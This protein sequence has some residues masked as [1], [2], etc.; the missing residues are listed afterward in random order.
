MAAFA[1]I[2]LV[3]VLM[4]WL[5]SRREAKWRSALEVLSEQLGF[6]RESEAKDAFVGEHQ[7]WR[8]WMGLQPHDVGKESKVLLPTL[9]LDVLAELPRDFVAVP[10]SWTRFLRR[11][12]LR[13]I[14][15]ARDRELDK[16]FIF[17]CDFV[18]QAK[19]LVMD[20]G[21]R[22]ALV[23]LGDGPVVGFIEKNQVG[24]AY[25]KEVPD[26]ATLRLHLDAM[27]AVASALRTALGDGRTGRTASR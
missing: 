13:G 15:T 20:A 24:L 18:E 27:A 9:R 3:A 7:G 10:R 17:Q 21:V 11:A 23:R 22:A 5:Q 6:G 12:L 8:V 25:M 14:F 1:L 2:V 4:Q 26:A 19:G 16:R